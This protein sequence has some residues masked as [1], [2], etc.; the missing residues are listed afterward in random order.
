MKTALQ[1]IRAAAGEMGLPQPTVVSG[2]TTTDTVQLLALLN[3]LAN[4]LMRDF[5]WQALCTEYRFTTQYLTT[6]GTLTSGS[7]IITG[8]ADT[9][10]LDSTYSILST[11]VNTDVYV[12]TLDSATQVTMTQAATASGAVSITFAKTKYAFPADYDRI[13]DRT[14]WDKTQHWRMIGPMTAQQWQ[15]LKSGYIATGPRIRFRQLGGTY[16]IWPALSTAEYLGFEYISNFPVRTAAGVAKG[17]F[18]LD[19]DTCI[20]QDGLMITGLKKYYYNAKG[21]GGE[22]DTAFSSL[23]GIAQANDMGSDTLSLGGNRLASTLIG[24][25]NIPDSGFNN[26]GS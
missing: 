15:W 9:T 20:F 1:L 3:R 2:S 8:L 21:L 16:Q 12:S 4:D 10:G 19:T 17:D 23:L 5:I 7:A 24:W 11:G 6:T 25:E 13:I 14:E 22:Y 18:T 26:F